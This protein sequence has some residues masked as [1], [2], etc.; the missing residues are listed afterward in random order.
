MHVPR[1]AQEMNRLRFSKYVLETKF[2]IRAIET[3]FAKK[4]TNAIVTDG[5]GQVA[6]ID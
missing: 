5:R 4:Y 1:A 6:E 3:S 2:A